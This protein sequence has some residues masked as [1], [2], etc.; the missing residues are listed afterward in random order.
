MK[1]ESRQRAHVKCACKLSVL[2]ERN[3]RVQELAQTS[4]RVAG[5]FYRPVGAVSDIGPEGG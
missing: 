2:P 4:N 1:F 5:S 3:T